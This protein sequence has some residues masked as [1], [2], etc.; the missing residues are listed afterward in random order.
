M[1]KTLSWSYCLA[2]ITIPLILFLWKYIPLFSPILEVYLSNLTLKLFA[3]LLLLFLNLVCLVGSK[4]LRWSSGI[5]ALFSSLLIVQCLSYAAWSYVRNPEVSPAETFT[6]LSHNVLYAGPCSRELAAIVEELSPDIIALQ[7]YNTE[8]AELLGPLI[9][10]MGY[11]EIAVNLPPTNDAFAFGIYSRFPIRNHRIFFTGGPYWKTTWPIQYLEFEFGGQ[12]IRLINLHLIPPH[13]PN[14]GLIPDPSQQVYLPGQMAEIYTQAGRA[15][16]PAVICGD[17]N[18]T[19]SSKYFARLRDYFVDSWLE[20]GAGFGATWLNSFPLFRIDYI[21]HT[22]HL[23][24]LSTRTIKN[25]YSDHL[26]LFTVF[27]INE[28]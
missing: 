24:T 20:S 3:G 28:P 27:T 13:D 26:A 23:K 7:E 8:H 15:E 6:F 16:F 21:L 17:F 19:P 2:V 5:A 11:R 9:K 4:K 18:Q 12:W 14:S 10:E 22:Q 1:K 25:D